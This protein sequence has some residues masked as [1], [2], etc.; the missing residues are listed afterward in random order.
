[1]FL[2]VQKYRGTRNKKELLEQMKDELGEDRKRE[3][4][5]EGN[6]NSNAVKQDIPVSGT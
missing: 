3:K 1:M 2:F 4:K 6:T 5:E